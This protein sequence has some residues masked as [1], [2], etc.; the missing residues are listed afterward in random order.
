MNFVLS[1]FTKDYVITLGNNDKLNSII[2]KYYKKWYND[3]YI[4]SYRDNFAESYYLFEGVAER[5]KADFEG[6]RYSYGFV[7]TSPYDVV[8]DGNLS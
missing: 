1:D 4:S 8:I 7:S 3:N 6:K 2:K 5:E